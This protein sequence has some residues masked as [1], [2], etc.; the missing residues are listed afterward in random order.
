MRSATDP[1]ATA[2]PIQ[3]VLIDLDCTLLDSVPDLAHAANAMR[4]E[5]ALPPLPKPLIATFVGKGV[6]NLVRRVLAGSLEA[7]EPTAS[8]FEQGRAAFYRHY[9][10][11]NGRHASLY[12][13]V[14]AGLSDMRAQGLR[15]AFV[16]NK[17]ETFTLPLLAHT[18]LAEFF[19]VVVSGDTC[20]RKKPNPMPMLHACAQ[21]Q[22]RPS[23]AV[24]IGDSINDAQAARAAG[25]RV[26]AVPYGYNEGMDVRNLDVDG[27]VATLMDAA[28]WMR[29][30]QDPSD[31]APTNF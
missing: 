7:P 23:E 17:P 25:I 22:V 18:G 21:L 5:L 2:A 26:L 9:H 30:R 27:I 15:L 4:I 29:A 10:E 6:D 11:V 1:E 24:A 3:A 19:D 20:E 28:Q 8:L 31:R 13:E 12:P 16:T 14:L